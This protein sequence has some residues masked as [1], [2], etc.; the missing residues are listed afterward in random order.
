MIFC[1]AENVALADPPALK[2]RQM[3]S[4]DIVDMNQIEPGVDEARHAAGAASTM[5]RPVGVGLT[6]QRP[7]RRRRIDH[8]G[9][10][11]L[12]LDHACTS[13]SAASLLRL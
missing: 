5:M 13:F 3:A 1:A 10:Q 12:R 8:D 2:R 7:D 9:R 4:G 11:A 6:S